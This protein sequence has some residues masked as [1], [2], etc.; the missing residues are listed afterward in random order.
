MNYSQI[1]LREYIEKQRVKWTQ[2][3]F[4]KLLVNGS[5]LSDSEIVYVYNQIVYNNALAEEK[6]KKVL[7][8]EFSRRSIIQFQR[9]ED[10]KRFYNESYVLKGKELFP[11]IWLSKQEVKRVL[12]LFLNLHSGCDSRCN[13]S[14]IK[15]DDSNVVYRQKNVFGPIGVKV[16]YLLSSLPPNFNLE[17]IDN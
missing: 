12:L 13:A 14:V 6:F 2:E 11:I 17:S 4:S 8:S 15:Y 1:E 16:I 3:L 9:F 10:D 7:S 5:R